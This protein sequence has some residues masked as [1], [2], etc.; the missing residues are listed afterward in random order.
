MHVGDLGD[1]GDCRARRRAWSA[2]GLRS[3]AQASACSRPP[4]PISKTFIRSPVA[5]SCFGVAIERETDK[6]AKQNSKP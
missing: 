5:I 1:A 2:E 4:A 3:S 6:S